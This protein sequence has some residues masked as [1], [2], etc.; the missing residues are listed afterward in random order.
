MIFMPLFLAGPAVGGVIRTYVGVT[1][2]FLVA[3]ALGLAGWA[4]LVWRVKE[5]RKPGVAAA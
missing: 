2:S 3:M 4:L 5:P 1:E